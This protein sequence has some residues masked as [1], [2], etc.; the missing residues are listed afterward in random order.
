MAAR[1]SKHWNYNPTLDIRMT[2]KKF[3]FEK[4]IEY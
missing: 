1:V 3:V 2:E 4:Y